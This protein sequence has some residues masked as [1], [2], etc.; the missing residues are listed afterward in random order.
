MIH[1]N[2]NLSK[3]AKV[4]QDALLKEGLAFEAIE[5]HSSTRT[6]K[7]AAQT[8]GCAVAQIEIIIISF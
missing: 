4:V 5:L 3:S 2:K 1:E 7:E 6:A 8:L